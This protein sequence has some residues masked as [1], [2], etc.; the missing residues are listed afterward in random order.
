MGCPT[1]KG[2]CI[3]FAKCFIN[4]GFLWRRFLGYCLNLE[5]IIGLSQNT[6]KFK[7]SFG[8]M[9]LLYERC[10]F[11]KIHTLWGM[12]C[13]YKTASVSPDRIVRTRAIV[14]IIIYLFIIVFI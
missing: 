13:F 10:V 4:I 6:L 7:S 9:T 5:M 12:V 14:F 8:K 1:G 2:G 3:D 11:D